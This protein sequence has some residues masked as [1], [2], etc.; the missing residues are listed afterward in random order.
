MTLTKYDRLSRSLQDLLAIVEEIRAK[1]AGFRHS[2]KISTQRLRQAASSSTSSPRSRS[3]SASGSW[4]VLMRAGRVPESRAD[5][6]SL[7]S[8]SNSVRR[9]VACA[10]RRVGGSP[11]PPGYLRSVQKRYGERDQN[12]RSAAKLGALFSQRIVGFTLSLRLQCCIAPQHDP[13]E[14]VSIRL[15]AVGTDVLG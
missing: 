12:S 7:P 3:S 14:F 5:Q 11:S 13:V 8:P 9:S 15:G 10:T 4:S 6:W 1:G 2:R